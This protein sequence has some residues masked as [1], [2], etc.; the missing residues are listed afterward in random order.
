MEQKEEKKKI[1]VKYNLSKYWEIVK[2]YK[3]QVAFLLFVISLGE[4]VKIAEKFLFKAVVDYGTDFSSGKILVENFKVILLTIGGIFILTHTIRTI[5]S[6]WAQRLIARTEA[7]TISDL[8]LKYFNHIISLSHGFFTTHK[9]GS[10]ISR[11]TRGANAMERLSDVFIFNV[12]PLLIQFVLTFASIVYF[13]SLS[14]TITVITVILFVAWSVFIQKKQEPIYVFAN[15]AEDAEKG[16]ISDIFTNVESVKY[17]GK[18]NFIKKKF[19]RLVDTT[20][21]ALFK[22]W[23]FYKI[24]ETG[25][26]AILGL[27]TLFLMFFSLRKLIAGEITL[28]SVSFIY[29]AFIGLTGPLF[30]FVYGIR[31]FYRSM[32]DF[33]ELFAYGKITQE[34][35]DAPNASE[36]KIQKGEIEFDNL[37]FDY[38]SRKIFKNFYLNIKENQRVALV[39]HSGSGKTT[40][41]KL[42]YRFYDV[43]KGGIKIDGRDIR[44]FKQESLRNEMAIVPQECVLFDDTIYNNILFSNPKASRKEV[45]KAIKLAQLDKTIANF[46]NKEE[47][48]V[49]ERGVKLSG[50]E[51]QRVSIA[52]ALLANKKI[53][54]LDEATS[55]LDSETEFEIQ[56]SLKKLMEGRTTIVIAHRLSTIMAADKIVVMRNGKIEQIGKHSELISQSGEYKHLW[57][58][59][60]GGYLVQGKD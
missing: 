45:L 58:L 31:G 34:V 37:T 27:G 60:K 32:A 15:K 33:Q 46:P 4:L 28:G 5:C 47:T 57:E 23:D 56:K 35:K 44:E 2:K 39:G 26:V 18:E 29:T 42:L 59:Q 43:N 38:G 8:K 53:L 16:N 51:K 20:R 36:C 9:T 1:E 10:L 41:V 14:A 6:W 52:R 12:I 54:V 30:G 11:L 48:I 21:E 22:T 49:G 13:D 40:L 7:D 55:A 17:F 24:M 25:Q 3:W 19:N 50:G